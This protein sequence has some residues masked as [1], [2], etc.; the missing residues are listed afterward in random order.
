MHGDGTPAFEATVRLRGG[1]MADQPVAQLG[2]GVSV[3]LDGLRDPAVPRQAVAIRE[4]RDS[5][6]AAADECDRCVEAAVAR[7]LGGSCMP[8]R[9]P[10][11]VR[12]FEVRQDVVEGELADL[13]AQAHGVRHLDLDPA[14]V[15]ESEVDFDR[16]VRVRSARQD[17]RVVAAFG[18]LEPEQEGLPCRPEYEPN[19]MELREGRAEVVLDLEVAATP[20]GLE[21]EGPVGGDEPVRR[22]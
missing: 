13:A 19:V 12:V 22:W 8:V 7:D 2:A 20:G 3:Q 16:V 1:S 10:G 4:Q 14:R 21:L 18:G 6:S 11:L 15:T 9:E 17:Q 5:E